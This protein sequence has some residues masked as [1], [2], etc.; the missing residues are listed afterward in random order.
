MTSL[1]PVQAVWRDSGSFLLVRS[2]LETIRIDNPGELATL[3]CRVADALGPGQM[4]VG[5]IGYAGTATEVIIV[6][7][8]SITALPEADSC[9]PFNLESEF[10]S[11]L[12]HSD[13]LHAIARIHH[14]LRAGDCYQVN[15]ARRFSARFS[16]DP[17]S[18]WLRL[19]QQH[20]APHSSFF[21]LGNGDCVFGVSPERFLQIRNGVV[22]TEP[23][24]GS[25]QRG[26]TPQQDQQIGEE[27][28]GNPKDR[29]ENLM[30]VDL[31]RNDLGKVCQAGSVK[32]EPLFELRRFSNVQHL[33][34]TITGQLRPEVHP[35]DALLSCFPGGSITGA[36]KKRAMEIIDELEPV[37]RGFYCGSQFVLDSDGNLDSNILI[38]TFQTHGDQIICHG[39]G[40]I[41]IDSDAE[42]EYQ[43][44]LFKVEKLMAALL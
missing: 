28:L 16:G 31:L 27:L 42:Q 15:F 19:N 3:S 10:T 36:P 5:L 41:V 7:Q 12:P 30:I 20:P 13:Y 34:S 14:Y 21:R 4:A 43:E 37:P 32:A 2:A 33:V 29:A 17:F 9:A 44:S 22:I 25:R 18:A 6:E 39:G 23:I 11:N 40:G 38:R 26:D 1:L 8:R 35:L 24:K